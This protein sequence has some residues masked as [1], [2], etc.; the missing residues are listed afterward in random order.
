MWVIT[1]HLKENIIFYEFDNE[2][3]ARETFEEIQGCKIL[4][5]VIY[6]NDPRFSLVTV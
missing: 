4:S 5:E 1:N 3:E 6:F 2:R